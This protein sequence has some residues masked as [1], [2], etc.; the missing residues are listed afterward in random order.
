MNSNEQKS[1]FFNRKYLSI[2]FY[3]IL[4]IF[5][6]ILIFKAL[7]DWNS[8]YSLMSRIFKILSPF[9]LGF[10]F[11][12]ILNPLV[13]WVNSHIFSKLIKKS[14]RA[15]FYLSLIFTYVI[16]IGLIIMLL[17]VVVPQIYTSLVDL[18]NTITQQYFVITGRLSEIPD[19]WHNIDTNSIISMINNS[20][21]QI[22]SYISGIT[23]NLI[24]FLYNTSLSVL[25]GFW[26]VIIGIIVSVYM[27][28]DRENLL[29]NIRRLAYA[30]IPA[31]AS[32]IILKTTRDS[33]AIFSNYVVGKS[34]DSLIIGCITFISMSAFRLD[35]VLLISVVVGVTNMI[36]YFG[37]FMGGAI[38][39]VILLIKSPINALIFG[40]MILVIQQFDGLYLGPKILGQSTGLKPLW[41]IF[42]IMV[43]GSLFGIV[44][45]LVGVPCVA[46]LSYILNIFIN[47]RLEKRDISYKDGKAYSINKKAK[48]KP[49]Q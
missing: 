44:G 11:A 32:T 10:I 45:M 47:Y 21:P 43:G 41:V 29:N 27:L 30:V 42:A 6:G 25:K 18:T 22:V 33:I 20:V 12:F 5:S 23:T 17:V 31:G 1:P 24:P 34:L 38:G 14:H 35:F 37:P 40:I 8:I 48:E 26:N 7:T 19:K 28:A 39:V 46:V 3:A 36:P 16:T 4:V 49:L 9:I 2:S 13:N 15:S